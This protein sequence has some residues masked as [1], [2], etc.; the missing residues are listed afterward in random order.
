MFNWSKNSN[1]FS[2]FNWSIL[3]FKFLTLQ[4]LLNCVQMTFFSIIESYI[5]FKGKN[6]K[7]ILKVSLD[8]IRFEYI[9]DTYNTKKDR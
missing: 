1:F 6:V 3:F 2:R 7:Y 9:V 5:Y 4:F 8:I